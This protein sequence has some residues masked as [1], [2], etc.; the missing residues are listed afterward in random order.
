MAYICTTS[1]DVALKVYGVISVLN[2][3]RDTYSV[4]WLSLDFQ[5]SI[6]VFRKI[7]ITKEQSSETTLQKVMEEDGDKVLLNLYIC[8]TNTDDQ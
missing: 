6:M 4:H 7:W 3:L 2:N 1:F 8:L 5:I